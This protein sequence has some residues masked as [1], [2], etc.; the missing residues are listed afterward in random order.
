MVGTQ[1][2]PYAS[3]IQLQNRFSGA[4]FSS[5]TVGQEEPLETPSHDVF[6]Q[7]SA[8]PLPN[9]PAPWQLSGPS[10]LE[11]TWGF[12]ATENLYNAI[13]EK[14]V[15]DEWRDS[16][17]PL[18]PLTFKA[19]IA[20]ESAFNK[21]AVSRTGAVGLV[22]ITTG[23]AEAY[24]VRTSP[25]PDQ[26][27]NPEVAVP[28]G[29]H[30]LR[31]KLAVIKN[32]NTSN[33]YAVP[34]ADYYAK[35]GLPSQ[36]QMT[37][38]SLAGYN[39]GGSTVVRAM[40]YAIADG[41]DPR[42]WDNLTRR[43]KDVKETPLYKAIRDTFGEAGAAA[44]Y[45][46]MSEYPEKIAA[47]QAREY[48]P[49]AGKKIMVDAGHGGSDPGARGPSGGRESD[50]NLAVSLKLRDRLESLGAEVRMTRDTDSNVAYPG[51]PQ[52]EEL[53]ARVKLA[54]EWPAQYYISVHSNSAE[55]TTAVGTETYH[56]RNASRTSK[57][58]AAAVHKE[59]VAATGFRDRGVKE[60]GFH[61]ITNTNMPA[62]LVET[63]FISNAQE[64]AALLNPEVQGRMA[65]A[66]ATGVAKV[67]G[68]N[69]AT[70]VV[71]PPS[72]VFDAPVEMQPI[73]R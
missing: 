61:V 35:N 69:P 64:E 22:Q 3:S 37:A 15:A 33:D 73:L 25:P 17:Y 6:G 30:I 52:Q 7:S 21:D 2:S 19:L 59:M 44:K 28:A 45:K 43:D 29:V 50:V 65:E 10:R 8:A 34:V 18:D 11:T 12:G 70:E 4:Q 27:R 47:I 49:L 58:M 71:A 72:R 42:D 9:Y 5:K 57:E 40:S 39:G 31:D 24:G 23:T 36:D 16:D 26:R 51:A 63:G 68:L 48:Q 53:R 1:I 56:S 38:L 62:I 13:I 41:V 46:E 67:A 54:N 32:P 14:G 20:Q 66:I 55:N 60:A